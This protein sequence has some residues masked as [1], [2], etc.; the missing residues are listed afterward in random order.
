MN[1][2]PAAE[3][4]NNTWLTDL[5]FLVDIIEHINE[6]YRKTQG[7]NKLVI[8]LNESICAFESKFELWEKQFRE[9]NPFY[10]LTL[11]SFLSDMGLINDVNTQNYSHKISALRNEFTI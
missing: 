5:S 11:K 6:L 1:G 2:C 10:C 4:S 9:N 7:R 8:D 3:L